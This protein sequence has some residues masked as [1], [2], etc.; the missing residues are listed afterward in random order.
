MGHEATASAGLLER[1]LQWSVP[2]IRM[3]IEHGA[4][5]ECEAS[6]LT[7]FSATCPA[8][9]TIPSK[10]EH[11]N[12]ECGLKTYEN[13]EQRCWLIGVLGKILARLM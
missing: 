7:S 12:S 13:R 1:V 8:S 4:R 11:T 3:R 9:H 2:N 5:T 10:D 6:W